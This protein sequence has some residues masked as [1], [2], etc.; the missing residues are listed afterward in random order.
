MKLK[1]INFNGVRDNGA[2]GLSIFDNGK[3]I[4]VGFIGEVLK[5]IPHLAN[6]DVDKTNYYLGD[7]FVVRL[8][9]VEG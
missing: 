3:E 6:R 1:D 5:S 2:F 7:T 4:A 9:A 8:K